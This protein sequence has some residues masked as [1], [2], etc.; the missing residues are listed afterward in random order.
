MATVMLWLFIPVAYLNL[1]PLLSLTQSLVLPHMRGL[2]CAILLFGA[3]IANLAL[4]PQLIGVMSDVFMN[5]SDAGADSL[6]RA[7]LVSTLTGFW[8]AYHL[9][10]AGK[11]IRSDLERA[12][13]RLQADANK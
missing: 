11:S 13:V 1:A 3:N 4:A 5:H 6:Q 12:G 7:L 8:A 10:A 2:T 9:W